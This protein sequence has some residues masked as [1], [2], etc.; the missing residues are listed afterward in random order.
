MGAQ[1]GWAAW[2]GITLA[3]RGRREAAVPL[4]ELVRRHAARRKT[5]DYE[6]TCEQGC[7]GC[8]ECT[9][10][11]ADDMEC[12]RCHGDGMDPLNDY[13]L[14]CPLCQGTQQP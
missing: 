12:E 13:L 5:M 11:E 4:D 6:R 9:D 3:M 1:R 2:M 7:N 10:Y 8:D 14:P